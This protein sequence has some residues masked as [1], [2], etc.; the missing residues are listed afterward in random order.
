MMPEGLLN[1]AF[2]PV[3][4]ADPKDPAVPAKVVTTRVA[5]AAFRI[6]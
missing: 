2:V 6:V 5:I 4:S 3:P 1:L